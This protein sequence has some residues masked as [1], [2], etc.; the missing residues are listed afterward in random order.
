MLHEVTVTW[1]DQAE[2]IS[3]DI[4]RVPRGFAVAMAHYVAQSRAG[5]GETGPGGSSQ[6]TPCTCG[7]VA[8]GNPEALATLVG[9]IVHRFDRR[10]CYVKKRESIGEPF[11]VAYLTGQFV[12]CPYHN[13]PYPSYNGGNCGG[14]W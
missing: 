10:P 3:W 8:T 6:R 7:E 4:E 12:R 1:D 2:V 11:Y 14:P 5:R 9:D 13:Y